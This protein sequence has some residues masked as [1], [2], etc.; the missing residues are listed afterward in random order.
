[1][2][3][4]CSM[5]GR[6]TRPVLG[7][8]RHTKTQKHCTKV[9][10]KIRNVGNRNQVSSITKTTTNCLTKINTKQDEITSKT[11]KIEPR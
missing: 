8:G 9:Q 10:Q 2:V 11:T 3:V 6:G 5:V 7:F 4:L 1:M